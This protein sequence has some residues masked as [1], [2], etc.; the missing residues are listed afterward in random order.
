MVI[1]ALSAPMSRAHAQY[2]T[3]PFLDWQTMSTERFTFYYA[4]GLSDWTRDVASRIES[5]DSAVSA[6]VGYR[7]RPRTRVVVDDP[8]G[9]SNGFAFTFTDAPSITFWA[10]PPNPREDIGNFR[11]WSEM[12]AVHEFAHVAHLARPSRNPLARSLWQLLPVRLGPIAVRAPR[13]V[14]E[15]YATYVEGRVTGSGRPN[16]AWRA[17]MLRQWA[18]EGRLPTYGQLSAWSDFNGGDFAY[19]AGSAFLE[20]LAESQGGGARGDSSLVYVWRRLT[21]VQRRSFDEAFIGVFGDSPQTLYGRFTVD[22]TARALAVQRELAAD[23]TS[24]GSMIQHLS[25]AT[26]DPAISRDGQ[27]VAIVLRALGRPSR[28][29]IWNS[30]E[31]PDTAAARAREEAAAR[32][33]ARDPE[34]VPARR[35]YPPAKKAL[36]T[37]L[38]RNGRTFDGPRFFADGRRV[39]LWRFAPRRDG[40]QRPELYIWDLTTRKVRRATRDAGVRDGDPSPDGRTAVATRCDGGRCAL[41][42]VDLQTG[43]VVVLVDPPVTSSFYRPRY[44]ADGHTIAVSV[45]ENGRWRLALVDV[46]TRNMRIVDPDDGANRFDAEWMAPD[47]LVATSDRGGIPNLERVDLRTARAQTLTR[48]TGAAVAPAPN[49]GDGSLW[50]LSLHSRGFDVRRLPHPSGIAPVPAM[51]STLVPAIP[52]APHAGVALSRH[53]VSASRAYGLGPHRFFWVP[54]GATGP[55]GTAGGF[56]LSNTD[57]VGRLSVLAQG[58]IG[59][60]P[61]WRGGALNAAWRGSRVAMEGAAFSARQM[62]SR[63]DADRVVG[64]LL[65]VWNSG[66]ELAA[67]LD[68]AGDGRSAAFRIGGSVARVARVPDDNVGSDTRAVGFARATGRVSHTFD[69][70]AISGALTLRGTLGSFASEDF[71]RWAAAARVISAGRATIPL[72][73]EASFGQVSRTAPA[74]EQFAVGGLTPPL[75]DDDVLSQ[76]VPFP[77]VPTGALVGDQ[78][79]LFRLALPTALTPYGTLAYARD[80]TGDYARQRAIGL[81]LALSTPPIPLVASPGARVSL[82]ASR[83]FDAPFTNLTR[84]YLGVSL[85]P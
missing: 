4:P 47:A 61:A 83:A 16:N 69:G 67:R 62:P 58:M 63:T 35:I 29:V 33:R 44:S 38:A 42:S 68:L 49:T 5:V 45:L 50:F 57:V 27:H 43:G 77:A 75:I 6:L 13:W 72:D 17:A 25:W 10:T 26:G 1:L 24:D 19:L 7:P 20:W 66:G 85:S 31:Q 32:S 84:V 59:S 54:T 70:G 53:A 11:A 74:Y 30:T 55:D 64:T 46:A 56:A 12:L 51:P 14:L 15:G 8:F 34:D 18:L 36:F 3:R 65:D 81:E 82:G 73:L 39:L 41:V 48:V 21:A 80:L 37:L 2:L 9:I 79:I 23:S 71:G 76:R 52:P 22:V 60:V 78:A 40:S 28:V